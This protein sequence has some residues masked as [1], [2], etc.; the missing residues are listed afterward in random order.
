MLYCVLSCTMLFH[1]VYWK[2]KYSRLFTSHLDSNH[3]WQFDSRK[4]PQTLCYHTSAVTAGSLR[5]TSVLAHYHPLKYH[6]SILSNDFH[7]ICFI[8]N[9]FYIICML[10]VVFILKIY[11]VSTYIIMKQTA[12]RKQM[13]LSNRF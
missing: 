2:F 13:I 4:F 12:D 11:F 7:F 9:L 8:Y 3:V 10:I 6:S 5:D 1:K